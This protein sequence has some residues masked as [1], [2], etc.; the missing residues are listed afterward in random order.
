MADPAEH[1]RPE[2]DAS[3]LRALHVSHGLPAGVT[4][5]RLRGL[6]FE[7][8]S[9]D[10]YVP[11]GALRNL[12]DRCRALTT[13]LPT[14][15]AFCLGTAAALSG[16]PLPRGWNVD[17]VHVAVPTDVEIP[18]RRALTSHQWQLPAEQVRTERG[19]PVV[20]AARTFLELAS[21]TSVE[22]LVSF[23]DA[24]LRSGQAK[25]DEIAQIVEG[26]HRRRGVLLARRAARMLDPRAEAPTESCVRVWMQLSG[27]PRATPNA[28][29]LDALG[30]PFA[31]ADLLVEEFSTIVEYEGRHHRDAEQFASDLRRR[32]RLQELGFRVVHLEKSM[33]ASRHEVV[34]TIAA[35]LRLQG[36]TGE[37]DFTFTSDWT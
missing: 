22:S 29:I 37:P 18:R 12:E 25:E 3:W 19:L 24:A 32:N 26:A 8:V 7:Q 5:S 13:V 23:G 10:L 16:L 28:W 20:S 15:A 36:W 6:A 21:R 35:V 14:G 31:R 1:D 30:A 27:L 11:T 9:R 2:A 4:R 17:A 34:R 33:L